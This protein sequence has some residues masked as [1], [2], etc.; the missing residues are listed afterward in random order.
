MKQKT[1]L[2]VVVGALVAAVFGMA[3]FAIVDDPAAHAADPYSRG[4]QART[5]RA[6]PAPRVQ[7][8]PR[9]STTPRDLRNPGITNRELQRD[10]SAT[11]NCRS[12]CGSSCQTMSCS[13]LNTSQCLSIRQ[14]C[15]MGCTSRC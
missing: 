8:A 14:N 12:R 9:I 15:R 3:P 2:M 11:S 4:V 10:L 7:P 6:V 13:G 5:P 1:R